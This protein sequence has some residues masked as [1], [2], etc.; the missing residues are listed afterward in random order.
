MSYINRK[1]IDSHW[2][3]FAIEGVLA[4]IFGWLM[5]FNPSSDVTSMVTLVSIFLFIMGI[6]ELVNSLHREHRKS[7]W[8]ITVVAAAINL[9]VALSLIFTLEQN[10]A[11]HLTVIAAYTFL[12]GFTELL[13]GFRIPDDLTDRF[14]WIVCG[15]CGIIM[16][17]VIFNSGHLPTADFVRFFGAYMLILGTSYLIYGVHNRAQKAELKLARS[18]AAKKRRKASP[19]KK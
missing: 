9:V 16:G 8:A 3:V 14:I 6:V 13:M 10:A 7:G 17:I 4:L 11:W 19:K 12:R 18:V 1:Y 5:L 15:I 2:L